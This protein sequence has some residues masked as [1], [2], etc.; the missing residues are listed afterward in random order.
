M[1]R[2][3]KSYNLNYYAADKNLGVTLSQ[4]AKGSH[5]LIVINCKEDN[6]IMAFLYFYH[7]RQTAKRQIKTML[8]E[9]MMKFAGTVSYILNINSKEQPYKIPNTKGNDGYSEADAGHFKKPLFKWE[10][11]GYRYIKVKNEYY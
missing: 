11:L 5:F 3:L 2:A 10:I 4:K 6:H 9:L 7:N 8:Q 1:S